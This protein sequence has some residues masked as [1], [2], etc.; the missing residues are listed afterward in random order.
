MAETRYR[1]GAD[2]LL[3]LLDAQ[4][5]LYQAQDDAITLR[6]QRLKASVA[7]FKALGGGWEAG[8]IR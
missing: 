2:T 6:L 3:T 1:A 8:K 4:R 7:L 5:S